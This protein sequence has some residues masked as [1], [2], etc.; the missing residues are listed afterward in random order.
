MVEN[1]EGIPKI[2][3]KCFKFTFYWSS[4]K[5]IVPV[6]SLYFSNIWTCI[7]RSLIWSYINVINAEMMIMITITK[8]HNTWPRCFFRGRTKG[9]D[10]ALFYVFLEEF[11]SRIFQGFA[12]IRM[13]RRKLRD[14][15]DSH[16]RRID[17]T[18]RN[19]VSFFH[20]A[21]D[22]TPGSLFNGPF[23]H[24]QEAASDCISTK[25]WTSSLQAFVLWLGLEFGEIPVAWPQSWGEEGWRVSWLFQGLVVG[26][27]KLKNDV[28]IRN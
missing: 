3:L 6:L 25:F 24:K 16:Q 15:L 20:L 22:W 12:P 19:F 2:I 1:R 4:S 13:R 27:W 14:W 8:I 18:C 10:G 23:P 7:N 5:I 9:T 17:M 28:K 11:H 26:I 21:S